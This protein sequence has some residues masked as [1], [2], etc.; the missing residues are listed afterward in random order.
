MM[1]SSLS[2]RHDIKTFSK[3]KEIRDYLAAKAT[4]FIGQIKKLTD[5]DI[6]KK[7]Y[8]NKKWSS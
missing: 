3:E 7:N 5:F 6:A 4:L 2:F 1:N 8:L